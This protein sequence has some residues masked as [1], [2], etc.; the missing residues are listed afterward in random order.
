MTSTPSRLARLARSA[1]L[2]LL[3]LTPTLAVAQDR[4]PA[5]AHPEWAAARAAAGRFGRAERSGSLDSIAAAMWPDAVLLPPGESEVKGHEAIFAFVTPGVSPDSTKASTPPTSSGGKVISAS[6]TMAVIWGTGSLARNG[7]SPRYY[8][9]VTVLEKRAG[10]WKVL[11]NTWNSR[12]APAP[13]EEFNDDWGPTV[14]PNRPSAKA[15]AER[16]AVTAADRMF[17]RVEFLGIMDSIVAA[18]WDDAVL[19]PSGKLYEIKGHEEI[20]AFLTPR[21]SA[22]SAKAS[23]LHRGSAISPGGDMAVLWAGRGRFIK[24]GPD[25]P[26][27]HYFKPVTIVEKRDGEWKVLLNSWNEIP[28]PEASADGGGSE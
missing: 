2:A 5:E 3:V 20:F 14:G 4:A 15:V 27:A 6:G 9:A 23:T 7:R 21:L 11:V 25:G 26:I 19:L 22:D 28:A 16:E 13:D 12:P 18:F 17:G 10:K 24:Q 1:A 8:K